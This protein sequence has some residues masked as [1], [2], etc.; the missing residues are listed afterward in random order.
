MEICVLNE[1]PL[2]VRPTIVTDADLSCYPATAW[3]ID[4]GS[5][6]GVTWQS[7]SPALPSIDSLGSPGARG[8]ASK[9][10]FAQGTPP[11]FGIC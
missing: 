6:G 9:V 2:S 11:L 4:K 1:T 8:A 3:M 7:R 5:A 10:A